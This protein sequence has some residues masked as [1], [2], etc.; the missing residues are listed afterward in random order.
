MW[1]IIL[2]LLSG[3]VTTVALL[4]VLGYQARR[5]VRLRRRLAKRTNALTRKEDEF[6]QKRRLTKQSLDRG[7]R[8]VQEFRARLVQYEDLQRENAAL[9]QD[10]FNLH[11]EA[12][13]TALDQEQLEA[14]QAEIARLT[15]E[16]A[17]RYLAENVRWIGKSIST[18]N[19]AASKKRL[20]AVIEACRGIGFDITPDREEE[21]L[22]DMK[23]LYEDAVRRE[24]QR[25]EQ[26]RIKERIREEQR[27]EREIQRELR[28]LDRER[29]AIEAALET[30]LQDAQDKHSAEIEGLRERLRAAE[31]K[32]TRAKSR[33]EM[34]RAGH[35]YI[36]SNIGA[37]GEGVYKIGMTRRLVPEDRIK[38]L[39]SASVPF[40][41]D[42]HMMISCD[43]APALENALHR[44]LHRSRVNRVNP[45]K[46]FFRSDVETIRR[47]VLQHHGEVDYI[48][49]PEALQFHE[50][51]QMSDED[52]EFVEGTIERLMSEVG[53]DAD[54]PE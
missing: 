28:R 31:E 48:A 20:L 16:L 30:A 12:R 46:E 23:Q 40:P 45:R 44:E 10:I 33:A 21:L 34:T 11:V 2:C 42:V 6:E 51:M 25:Q 35:V 36:I 22:Q 3:V 39:A 14:R 50:S 54:T 47:L 7:I 24:I 1:Y 27:L 29:A 38:E 53:E 19:F 26:A 37:F 15:D 5:L 9:K 18:S 32:C 41:F 52:A 43:D 13:K 17:S 4:T 8:Q 49:D